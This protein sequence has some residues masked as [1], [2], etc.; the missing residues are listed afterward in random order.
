M[1]EK[2]PCLNHLRVD[3]QFAGKIVLACATL[4]NIALQ[5]AREDLVEQIEL[6]ENNDVYIDNFEEYE[7]YED[8][9]DENAI[10]NTLLRWFQ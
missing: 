10:I 5:V 8:H 1:R 9:G 2:F 6:V 7:E 4:H 3:P